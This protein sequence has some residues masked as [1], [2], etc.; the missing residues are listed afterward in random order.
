MAVMVFNIMVSS[1]HKDQYDYISV[2]LY[3]VSLAV[4]SWIK[5]NLIPPTPFFQFQVWQQFS[6]ETGH[7]I[8]TKLQLYHTSSHRGRGVWHLQY[9]EWGDQGCPHNVG[10]F[11]GWFYSQYTTPCNY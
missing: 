10:H 8:T 3:V 7:C 4:N 9:L 2:I 6:Q 11:L 1:L 5:L